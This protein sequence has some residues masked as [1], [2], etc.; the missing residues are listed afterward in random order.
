M[1]TPASRA[2][3]VLV[4]AQN[5]DGGWGYLSGGSWTEPTA[6][7]LLSLKGEDRAGEARGRASAYL[8]TLQRPDGGWPPHRSVA[9]STWVTALAVLA[10]GEELDGAKLGAAVGWLLRVRG[11]ESGFWHRLRLR[12]L[13]VDRGP[14][15]GEG[16]PWFGETAA[17]VTPTA[18]TILA[19]LKVRPR[20]LAAG[21]DERLSAARRYLWS[22]MCQ[23]GG[24]NH[25]STRALGYDAPSYPE[26][27]GA[28]LLA[29][30]GDR[31]PELPRALAAAERHFRECRSSSGRNWLRLGLAAHA[32]LVPGPAEDEPPARGVMDTALSL[33]AERTGAGR[34]PLTE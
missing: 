23:D 19:L 7:A 17:W 10:L 30:R 4:R 14:G 34:D 11:R 29:L 26:T 33:L 24:W 15:E 22:R 2:A 12:L 5:P 1:E 31:P 9:R 32:R 6:L 8:R 3:A 16:W 25:G 18:M 13:G 21:A 27:T 28:A 20:G